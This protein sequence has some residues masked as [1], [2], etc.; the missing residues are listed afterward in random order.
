MSTDARVVCAARWPKTRSPSDS[1]PATSARWPARSRWWSPTTPPAG[2]SCARSTRTPGRPRSSASPARPGA[3]K[4]TLIGALIKLRRAAER[5]VAVL[6]IDPSSPVHPRRAARRSHPPD[7]ALPGPRRL[8]PLDGQPRRARRAQRGGAAGR[9]AHGR[10]RQG[11]RLPGDGGRRPGRGRHHRP[12]R[13]RRARPHARLGRLDPGAEGRDHGDPRRHRR[14]QGRP[15]ADRHDGARDPRRALA[16]ARSAAGACRS[17]RPRPCAARASRRW[18]SSSTPT[19]P[20]SSA[21]GTLS[22]RRRRNLR[23][24]VL[25]LCTFRLRRAPG[26]APG[27]RTTSSPRCSTRS[28]RGAWIPRARRRTILERFDAGEAA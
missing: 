6:S 20:T 11:R 22:E 12:R 4:S 23:N 18:S 25:G 1:S 7:R 26:G 8:H 19:A 16:R 17:S 3:G 2:S 14:Q 15:P 13:H 28:S 9:A 5:E 24:E 10:R 21:E 27:A